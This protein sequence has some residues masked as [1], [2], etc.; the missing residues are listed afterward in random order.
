MRLLAV[1]SAIAVVVSYLPQ[2]LLAVIADDMDADAFAVGW[3]AAA[4]QLGYAVGLVFLLPL[5][6]AVRPRKQMQLQ[7][8]A[9]GCFL[10]I[11]AGSEQIW[12]LA[13]ALFLA[14]AVSNIAQIIVPLAI[15]FSPI[16]EIGRTTAVLTGALLFGVFGGRIVAGF[17][18]EEFGWRVPILV[19]A[20]FMF[21][22][23]PVVRS[24][25]G[26][27]TQAPARQSYASLMRSLP[28]IARQNSALM[29]SAGI[30]FLVFAGFNALWTVLVLQLTRPTIGWS[31]SEAGLVGVVGLAAGYLTQFSGPLVDMHG[32]SRVLMISTVLGTVSAL[33]ILVST[34]NVVLLIIGLFGVTVANQ[35]AQVANQARV[36]TT[37]EEAARANTVYMA[38]TFL[39]GA[40]GAATGSFVFAI[41]GMTATAVCSFGLLLASCGI[42]LT[43]LRHGRAA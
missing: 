14:G 26:K 1:T 32:T 25:I 6:D 21:A 40:L 7:L 16:G 37:V 17:L 39:G 34:D 19:L 36:L 13:V 33:A 5:S 2:P 11:G 12:Q 18:G 9:A 43:V 29:Q 20:G 10:I 15:R 31:S 42:A 41:G 4:A 30:Q 8:L 35:T 38:C 22:L 27:S 3:V 28:R 23:V 24:C